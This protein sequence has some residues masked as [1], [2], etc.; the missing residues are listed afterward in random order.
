MH[1]FIRWTAETS[2]SPLSG[3][4]LPSKYSTTGDGTTG[5]SPRKASPVEPS[6]DRKSPSLITTPRPGPGQSCRD[7]IDL[8]L[9]GAADRGLAHSRATTAAWLVLP[10]AGE[11]AGS[12]H[13]SGQVF[14]RGLPAQQDGGYPLLGHGHGSR[15]VEDLLADR[16]TR[17]RRD[18]LGQ[19]GALRLVAESKRGNINWTSCAP[20]TRRTASSMSM[21]PSSTSWTAIRNAAPAVRLPTRVWSM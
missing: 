10:A 7:D 18:C 6:I 2:S 1:G 19:R 8:Q 16:G 4:R 15:A 5:T 20:E 12:G 9:L 3:S 21:T 14:G 13:H 11:D 17:R